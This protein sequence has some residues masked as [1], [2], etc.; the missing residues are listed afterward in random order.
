MGCPVADEIM[1]VLSTRPYY[2]V[3]LTV[4][5]YAVAFAAAVNAS[6]NF[7]PNWITS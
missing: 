5:F 3:N 2:N 6:G 7:I 4:R 1:A